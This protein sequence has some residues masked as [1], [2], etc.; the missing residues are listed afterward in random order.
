[1]VVALGKP[2]GFRS[3]SFRNVTPDSGFRGDGMDKRPS[4]K[5]DVVDET[6][7]VQP[8]RQDLVKVRGTNSLYHYNAIHSWR[9]ERDGQVRNIYA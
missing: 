3:R 4:C 8:S 1:M 9:V 2:L 7:Y 5:A 6:G